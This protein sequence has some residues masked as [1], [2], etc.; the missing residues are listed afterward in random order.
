MEFS[1]LIASGAFDDGQYSTSIPTGWM[2]GRTTYGGL[3]AALC[4]DVAK[5]SFPDL[6]PLRSAMISFIG[7]A[8]GDVT[9]QARILRQGKSVTFVEADIA[10]EKG[11]ATRSQFA[12]GGARA[13]MFDHTFSP[14]PDYKAP[15]DCEVYIP[16]EFGPTFAVHFESRLVRGARPGT[17]STEHDH[18]IW[19][20]HKDPKATDMTALLAIA[21]MP[22]PAVLPM[23]KEFAPI[24]SMTWM[25]NVVVEKPQTRDGWW[26]M[27][28]RAETARD[29]YSSQ[30]MLVWNR[31]GELVTTGRQSVAVFI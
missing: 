29:G 18:L 17:G 26:L 6:P 27:Q 22:P 4:L 14:K 5:R 16:E 12:F 3:S 2:Q 15:E 30:D 10:G 1:D 11:L 21:D 23:F 9:G 25:V 28:T 13:S 19:I 31:D 8:G 24:S 7:P 20:R